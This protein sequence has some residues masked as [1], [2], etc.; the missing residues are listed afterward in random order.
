[1]GFLGARLFR[2]ENPDLGGWI[3]LD[4]GGVGQARSKTDI[5]M[6]NLC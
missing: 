3:S 2:F 4:F 5:F 6:S 1:L